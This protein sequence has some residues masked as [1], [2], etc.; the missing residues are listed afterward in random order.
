MTETSQQILSLEAF[1][2]WTTDKQGWLFRGMQRANWRLTTTI[3]RFVYASG[4]PRPELEATLYLDFLRRA[5]SYLPQQLVPA[6]DDV[7]RWW[8]IMQHYGAPTRLLDFSQSPWV[9]LFFAMEGLNDDGADHVVVAVNPEECRRRLAP[10]L[11]PFSDP[12]TVDRALEQLQ[13]EQAQLVIASFQRRIAV[14]GVMPLE[15]WIYDDRQAA[16]QSAFLMGMNTVQTFEKNLEA[17]EATS[18]L[19]RRA[20]IPSGLRRDFLRGLRR[21]NI[22]SASLYPG[23]EGFA[24]SLRTARI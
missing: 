10:T 22:T 19:V 9:A 21:M 20:N 23:L 8:G 13:Y 17:V 18:A 11:A 24:R 1:E 12:P 15:P 6:D 2:V 7:F 4:Q 5:R 16:Q 14:S 3:E